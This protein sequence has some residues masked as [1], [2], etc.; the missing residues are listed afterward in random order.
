MSVI[1]EVQHPWK[2]LWKGERCWFSG[3]DNVT[4]WA[5]GEAEGQWKVGRS[6]GERPQDT[7]ER[8]AV[9]DPIG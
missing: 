3:T 5:T 1:C 4:H 7:N 6:L 8:L 2:I 9:R